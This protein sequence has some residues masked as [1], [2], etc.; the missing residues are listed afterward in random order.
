MTGQRR[1]RRRHG[2]RRALVMTGTLW[3]TVA[4]NWPRGFVFGAALGPV[5][6]TGCVRAPGR[7]SSP[8]RRPGP[9]G[10]SREYRPGPWL[11]WSVRVAASYPYELRLPLAPYRFVWRDQPAVAAAK[12]A[13]ELYSEEC[14]TH[15]DGTTT[16]IREYRADGSLLIL[17][18]RGEIE[19]T[20]NA[21]DPYAADPVSVVRLP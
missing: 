12:N 3:G 9:V 2:L 1:H 14:Y 21:Q 11:D 5:P 6:A 4:Y 17:S 8:L 19:L 18:D 10:Y 15:A 20:D 16:I 13:N 7:R